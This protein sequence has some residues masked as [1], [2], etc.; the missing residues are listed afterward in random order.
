MCSHISSTIKDSNNPNRHLSRDGGREGRLIRPS[1]KCKPSTVLALEFLPG[2]ESL[3]ATRTPG[4]NCSVSL[5]GDQ[6]C[7]LNLPRTQP[8]WREMLRPEFAA[9]H[10]S[11]HSIFWTLDSIDF[12]PTHAVEKVQSVH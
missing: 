1:K 3:C 5:E 8:P 4:L 6:R 9:S 12:H 7:T 11:S 2:F 10:A